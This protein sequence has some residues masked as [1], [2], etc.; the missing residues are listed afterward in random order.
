[1]ETWSEVWKL[2]IDLPYGSKYE[3]LFS[4]YKEAAIEHMYLE[5]EGINVEE[6]TIKQILGA[7]TNETSN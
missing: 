2:E 1:M 6:F 4:S 7:N 3:C 5:S